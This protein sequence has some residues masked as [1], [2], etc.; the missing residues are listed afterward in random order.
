MGFDV[1]NLETEAL[2]PEQIVNGL[3][4]NP[5]HW[6]VAQK[7]QYDDFGWRHKIHAGKS[8]AARAG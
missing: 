6:E 4:G 2:E 1:I 8:E 7:A 3:P 5:R